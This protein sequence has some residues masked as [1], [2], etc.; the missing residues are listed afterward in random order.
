MTTAAQYLVKEAQTVLQDLAGVRWPASDLVVYLNDAQRDLIVV[1]PDANAITASVTTVEGARQQ[2]PATAASLIDVI[3]NTA[4]TKRAM[5]KV[6]MSVLDAVSPNWQSATGVTE[7][8][9]F[10]YDAREPNIFYVYPPSAIAGGS[11]EM[12]YSG[13]PAPIAAPSGDGKAYSTVTGNILVNDQWSTAL[14]NYMLARAYSKDVEYGGNLE[15]AAAYM[16]AFT[17]TI[18]SQL[19][20]SQT[21]APKN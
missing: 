4:G 2:L 17:A 1:R 11:V 3:R 8:V 21:V 15:L 16:Q 10:I 6:E 20:S 7:F 13:Y 5:R 12:V 19:Q 18:S 14:L 9:H